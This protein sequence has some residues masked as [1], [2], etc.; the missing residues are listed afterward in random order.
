VFPARRVL[1]TN[2]E[3]LKRKKRKA[4]PRQRHMKK[5]GEEKRGD[6]DKRQ[7]L[8]VHSDA[9]GRGCF[10]SFSRRLGRPGYM[11]D[12]PDSMLYLYNSRADVDRRAPDRLEEHL[13]DA[14]VLDVD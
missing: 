9:K 1:N 5:G 12:L 14:R 3:F 13:C 11:L 4:A 7:G 8:D 2:I 6:N 10:I